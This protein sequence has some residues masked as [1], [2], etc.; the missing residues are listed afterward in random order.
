[1]RPKAEIVS[2]TAV[3]SESKLLTSIPGRM[4]TRR[5]TPEKP[6]S[7][8]SLTMRARASV[9]S[10]SR[11]ATSMTLAPARAR[12]RAIWP[13]IPA[14]P[15]VMRATFPRCSPVMFSVKPGMAFRAPVAS[16]MLAGT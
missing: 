7:S 14:D 3:R 8:S 1:M 5:S 2:S 10:L 16:E 4:R 15:P 13:P 12:S 6:M 9:S 11:R